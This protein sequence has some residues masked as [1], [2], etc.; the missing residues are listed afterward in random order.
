MIYGL[1]LPYLL[2]TAN[3]ACTSSTSSTNDLQSALEQGGEGYI[4]QLC[5]GETYNLDQV[6]NYTAPNQVSY[7]PFQSGIKLIL[8]GNIYRGIPDGRDASY[9]SCGR[10]QYIISCSSD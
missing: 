5:A 7:L 3:A 6:L 9:A 1:V 10:V 4:L 8:K 2:S